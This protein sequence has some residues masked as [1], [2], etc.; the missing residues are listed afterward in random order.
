MLLEWEVTF[1]SKTYNSGSIN[2]KLVTL[3]P[4]IIKCFVKED[5]RNKIKQTYYK[6]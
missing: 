4:V 5:M 1:S 3:D 6:P 2:E